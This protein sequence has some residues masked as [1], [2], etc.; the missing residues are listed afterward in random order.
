MPSTITLKITGPVPL[1]GK[2]PGETFRVKADDE[3]NPVDLYW[4]RRLADEA[5][6][7]CGAVRIVTSPAAAEEPAADTAEP[8]PAVPASAT[9]APATRSKKA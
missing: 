1:G 5:A 8:S 7:A 4:R 6:Y 2:R 9:P 3:G